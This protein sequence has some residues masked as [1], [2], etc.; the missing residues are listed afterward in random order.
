MHTVNDKVQYGATNRDYYVAHRNC[1][2][3]MISTCCLLVICANTCVKFTMDYSPCD[4]ICRLLSTFYSFQLYVYLFYYF[5][6][7]LFNCLILFILFFFF[8]YR[9]KR[10]IVQPSLASVTIYSG[11]DDHHNRCDR[12]WATIDTILRVDNHRAQT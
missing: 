8:L 6:I 12:L 10:Y 3:S 4:R 5:I 2:V 11:D 1:F 7:F 9:S